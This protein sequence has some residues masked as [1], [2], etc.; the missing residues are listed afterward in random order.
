ME[1]P[2]KLTKYASLA[3]SC[4]IGGEGEYFVRTFCAPTKAV[5]DELVKRWNAHAALKSALEHERML[6]D[7]EPN[8]WGHKC[9]WCQNCTD[10][11]AIETRAA[12]ATLSEG[13][14]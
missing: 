10:R 11:V 1:L 13:E 2:E 12:L 7:R 8:P 14:K 6:R 3:I 9:L 4:D 5:R